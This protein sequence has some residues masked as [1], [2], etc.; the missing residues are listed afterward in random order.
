[1]CDINKRN[2]VVSTFGMIIMIYSLVMFSIDKQ[3]EPA[4]LNMLL[5]LGTVIYGR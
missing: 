3:F 4:F 1:M 2:F 5:G